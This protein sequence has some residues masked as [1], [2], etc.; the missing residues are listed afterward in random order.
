MSSPPSAQLQL[1]HSPSLQP[2]I[3]PENG[4]FNSDTDL[5]FLDASEMLINGCKFFVCNFERDIAE[6]DAA[7]NGGFES[8]AL[9]LF[10][11][12]MSISIVIRFCCEN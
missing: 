3:S 1:S 11:K 4:G 10:T 8:D 6:D 7:E 12:F 2:S 9:H 5:Q